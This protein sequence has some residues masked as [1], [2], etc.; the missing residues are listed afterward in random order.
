MLDSLV[1]F[2]LILWVALLPDRL[3]YDEG[4]DDEGGSR[5]SKPAGISAIR[6]VPC[7]THLST[8]LVI[9]ASCFDLRD[10]LQLHMLTPPGL[11]TFPLGKDFCFSKISKWNGQYPRRACRTPCRRIAA[12]DRAT[13]SHRAV[14]SS[15]IDQLWLPM[16]D[17]R[18]PWQ[19]RS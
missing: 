12:R 6:N 13:E 8:N 1:F 18:R 9:R 15:H 16:T 4:G 5:R 17:G 2:F 11:K 7:V 10:S 3:G 14:N 19:G